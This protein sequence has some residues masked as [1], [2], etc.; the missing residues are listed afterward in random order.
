MSKLLGVAFG[1]NLEVQ[2]VNAFLMEKIQKKFK[3]W[4]TIHLAIA[5]IGIIVNSILNFSLWFFMAIWYGSIKAIWKCKAML[6]NYLWN[7]WDHNTKTKVYWID[8]VQNKKIGG[9]NLVDLENTLNAFLCKWVLKALKHD[10]SNL[11]TFLRCTN[12]MRWINPI[13]PNTKNEYLMFIGSW[14][15]VTYHLLDLGFGAKY[16]QLG[17]WWVRLSTLNLLLLLKQFIV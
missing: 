14:S 4:S 10:V 2:D 1:L 7:G 6:R 11:K 5:K 9:L 12:P 15:K 16:L 17:R 8:C 3:F 13:H